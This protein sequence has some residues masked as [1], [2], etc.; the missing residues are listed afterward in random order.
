MSVI[1]INKAVAAKLHVTNEE[2]KKFSGENKKLKEDNEVLTEE[3]RRLSVFSSGRMLEILLPQSTTTTTTTTTK[4]TT[5]KT[6][7]V[8]ID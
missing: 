7:T 2:N 1:G 4:T 3:N 5:T 6:T 8:H